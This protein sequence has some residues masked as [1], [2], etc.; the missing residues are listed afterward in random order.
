MSQTANGNIYVLFVMLI[1]GIVLALKWKN[2]QQFFYVTSIFISI[3]I[4][5]A[6]ITRLANYENANFFS[7]AVVDVSYFTLALPYCLANL[8]S[9]LKIEK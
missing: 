3:F 1:V 6:Q 2:T 5:A 9:S 7:D 8:T 4:L